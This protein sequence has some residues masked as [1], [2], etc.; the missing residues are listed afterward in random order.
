L[1]EQR[2]A[3]P[4]ARRRTGRWL[5][6]LACLVLAATALWTWWPALVPGLSPFVAVTSILSTRALH[7][8]AWLGLAA[9]VV[10]LW[11]PRWFCRWVCPLGLC[12]DG[13][14]HA[15]RKLG[16]RSA[17]P[18]PLGQ[19]IVWLTLGGAF[20]GYPALLWLDPLALFAGLFRLTGPHAWYGLV[21]VAAV[22]VASALW[23][24]LWC[25][26]ACPLG[27]SQ[28]LLSQA[29][30]RLRR[31]Q[32][33]TDSA[34]WNGPLARRAVLGIG[35]GVATATAARLT[36]AS[37][38]RALRPPGAIDEP[39][40]LGV[41][42]RCG[43]CIRA[44]PTRIIE[45]ALGGHGLTSLLT[46]VLRFESGYC[47]EDCTRCT[48]VCPSGALARVPIQEKPDVRIGLPRVDMN[49][50][51]LGEER[52]CSEC[53]R[54]C[55]YEAIQYVFS[56]AEYT[57]IPRIDREKCNGCGAC[58]AYCPTQ[59]KKAITVVANQT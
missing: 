53:K 3:T 47:R 50:C 27:A 42:V 10:M 55:P 33:R 30:L 57:L 35:V 6:R 38:S 11:R 49:V 32:P 52:E 29:T 56:E 9:G 8:T 31:R 28:D 20:V 5:I 24:H 34:R 54:W 36:R 48:A 25:A 7:A 16:R 2:G 18:I 51:L 23:P 13:A 14:S 43:N 21:P 22:L 40:F 45:P 59:P 26:S 46:P 12:A 39:E 15:G 19:W 41:C 4:P 58:E 17:R 37:A 44:C 1:N